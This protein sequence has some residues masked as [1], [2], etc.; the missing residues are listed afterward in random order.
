M[1]EHVLR[2]DRPVGWIGGVRVACAHDLAASNAA[3]GHGD[4]PDPGPVVAAAGC[5]QPR[6]AA[7]LACGDHECAIQAA[8]AIEVVDQGREG[9]IEVRQQ[10]ASVV[11]Q[12]AERRRA[13]AVPGDPVEHGLEHVDRDHADAGFDQAAR[14]Q[15]ALPERGATVLIT[16]ATGL[17]S[18]GR[19]DSRP[20]YPSS[21]RSSSARART[22]AACAS[23]SGPAGSAPRE[24]GSQR[25][26]ARRTSVH[27]GC[28][29]RWP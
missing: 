10:H 7:E 1:R 24:N 20:R 26:R 23:K 25:R 19:R 27:A 14:E 8:A 28:R 13:V 15:A 6:R 18:R 3:A 4:A 21:T 22:Q 12:R 29:S 2:R 16:E 9:T 17:K 5:V 11:V